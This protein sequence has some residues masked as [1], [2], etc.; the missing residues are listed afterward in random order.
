MRAIWNGEVIAESDDTVVAEGNDYFP[1]A[2]VRRD[3]LEPSDK[4]TR[5]HWKG[6][7]NYYS[8]KVGDKVNKD[9]AWFYPDPSAEASAIRDRVAFWRGVKIERGAVPARLAEVPTDASCEVLPAPA[10]GPTW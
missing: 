2:S 1:L 7:A 6:I 5:C 3:V 10:E 9:A 8:I 4:Q